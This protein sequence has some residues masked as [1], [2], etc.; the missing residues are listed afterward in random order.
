[1]EVIYKNPSDR[2]KNLQV[3]KVYEVRS[4]NGDWYAI[5]NDAGKEANYHRKLFEVIPV[6][7]PE[8]IWSIGEIRLTNQDGNHGNYNVPILLNEVEEGILPLYLNSVN[9]SCGI[10]YIGSIQ[11]AID[12]L[13]SEDMP[14]SR[15]AELL[16]E[17]LQSVLVRHNV[18]F[19]IISVTNAVEDFIELLKNHLGDRATTTP[20]K[21]NP[22]SGNEICVMVIEKED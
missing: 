12:I 10:V 8:R 2:I 6:P 22:N 16:A 13:E 4:E 7:P 3:E 1:M 20:W 15:K 11:T 21:V 18:R 5:L 14:T 9:I 19:G 17:A